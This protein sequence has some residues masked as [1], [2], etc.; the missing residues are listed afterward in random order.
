MKSAD[1]YF[2]FISQIPA[3]SSLQPGGCLK[4]HNGPVRAH[5]AWKEQPIEVSSKIQRPSALPAGE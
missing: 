2:H 5:A 3:G 4:Q 1:W